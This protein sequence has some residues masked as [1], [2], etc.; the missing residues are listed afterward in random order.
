MTNIKSTRSACVLRVFSYINAL[1]VKTD[2]T[3]TIT[4]DLLDT[5]EHVISK[6]I[7]SCSISRS[8]GAASATFSVTLKLVNDYK[9]MFRPGDWVLIYLDKAS[10][11]DLKSGTNKGLK[12]IG[13]IDRISTSR[14]VA[15]NGA[16]IETCR[17]DGRDI[18]KIFEKT[19]LFYDSTLAD[20]SLQRVILFATAL[21]KSGNPQDFVNVY[22]DLFLGK[23]AKEFLADS[24]KSPVLFQ[25][26]MPPKVYR[27]LKG[28][29]RTKFTV[30]AFYDILKR[31]FDDYSKEG[32]SVGK[33]VGKDL[34]GNL[35]QL[36]QQGCNSIVNEIYLDTKTRDDS[37][38]PVLTMRQIPMTKN[39]L[40]ALSKNGIFVSEKDILTD[41][42]GFS[43]HEKYNYLII[44][45]GQNFLPNQ[46][47]LI[48]AR[49]KKLPVV[50]IDSLKRYGLNRVDRTT[51]YA[52]HDRRNKKEAG[53]SNFSLIGKW[54]E[55]IS[56]Y[57]FGYHKY[58]T[59]TIIIEDR[60]D[61]EVGEFIRIYDRNRMYMVE[62]Y[63][64]NWNFLE[65]II[66]TLQVTH[67]MMTNGDYIEKDSTDPNLPPLIITDD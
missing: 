50:D 13:N 8:K 63:S 67:G 36:I 30:T 7:I 9:K 25:M 1:P 35:W 40:V 10:E 20:E 14:S 62:G 39:E 29:E 45:D 58:E 19:Q 53:F 66:T 11:I 54:A 52:L 16:I 49:K 23:G 26:L 12:L 60:T 5:T 46:T 64:Y 28:G 56:E 34:V 42:L 18:G 51:E 47:Y 44:R 59:G 2:R 17:I 37:V 33:D 27:V 55:R 22:L 65:P 57:W 3:E 48:N 32:F 21:V 43:D 61:F 31:E 24:S 6:G 15:D 41:D 4:K 38:V